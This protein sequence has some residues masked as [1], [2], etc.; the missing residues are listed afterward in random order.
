MSLVYVAAPLCD[1]AR[2]QAFEQK[3][4]AKGH[5][6][7]FR[8]WDPKIGEG[9]SLKEL[10]AMEVGAVRES[11]ALVLLA[12]PGSRG[13][14]FVEFGVALGFGLRC[15]VVRE[16]QPDDTSCVFFQAPR[17]EWARTEDEAVE[18][19]DKYAAPWE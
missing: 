11:E 5:Y 17:V 14:M 15:V 16:K 4:R 19:V 1:A 12:G 13:G 3:L 18:K 8:W 2:A 7:A 6:P 10:A 9:Y